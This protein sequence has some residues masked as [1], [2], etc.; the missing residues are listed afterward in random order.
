MPGA[1]SNRP[2]HGRLGLA[3]MRLASVNRTIPLCRSRKSVRKRSSPDS[4]AAPF[5][6]T[7]AYVDQ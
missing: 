6:P 4:K 2:S 5:P 7:E 3:V 1:T